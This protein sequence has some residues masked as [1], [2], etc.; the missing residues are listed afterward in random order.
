M[1]GQVVVAVAL[2]EAAINLVHQR[3]HVGVVDMVVRADI[4]IKDEKAAGHQHAVHE[5]IHS[6]DIHEMMDCRLHENDVERRVGKVLVQ[7][8]ASLQVDASG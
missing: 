6:L 5:P 1:F 4:F 2:G 7:Y 8:V 3:H